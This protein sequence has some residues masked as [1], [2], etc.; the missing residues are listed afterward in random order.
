MRVNLFATLRHA[1]GQKTIH[2]EVPKGCSAQTVLDVLFESYPVLIPL[3]LDEDRNLS[4]FVHM[5][6]NGR[7]AV[8]LPLGLNTTV[9]G[10][11]TLD[12]FPAVAGGSGS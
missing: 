8:L 9:D 7:S 1:V 6:I 2:L 11:E 10:S 3:M 12:F 4:R 5:F